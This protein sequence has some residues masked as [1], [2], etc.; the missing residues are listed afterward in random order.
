MQRTVNAPDWQ[1][2]CHNN[3]P[4][5]WIT[6]VS[7]LVIVCADRYPQSYSLCRFMFATT[8]TTLRFSSQLSHSGVWCD[9][10]LSYSLTV[11]QQPWITE[12]SWRVYTRLWWPFSS[13]CPSSLASLERGWGRAEM[14]LCHEQNSRLGSGQ[15]VGGVG[16]TNAYWQCGLFPSNTQVRIHYV[17]THTLL[18]PFSCSWSLCNTHTHTHSDLILALPRSCKWWD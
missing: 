4:P 11:S 10:L 16:Y 17:H 13:T 18:S 6:P 12:M 5:L 9:I 7:D 3:M 2:V 15:W 8:K 14:V 1:E